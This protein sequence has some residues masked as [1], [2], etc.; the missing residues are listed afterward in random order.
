MCTPSPKP[1][2]YSYG[3]RAALPWTN[4]GEERVGNV[5]QSCQRREAKRIA[6]LHFSANHLQK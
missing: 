1:T 3:G 6:F 4:E 2:V 5:H